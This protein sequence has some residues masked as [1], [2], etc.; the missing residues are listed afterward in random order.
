[1]ELEH[2]FLYV[3][4][5]CMPAECTGSYWV[6]EAV[7]VHALWSRCCRSPLSPKVLELPR[8]PSSDQP[9]AP[10]AVCLRAY[11]GHWS[12]NACGRVGW[13]CQRM[14]APQQQPHLLQ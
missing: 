11:S 10:A 6:T 7:E 9:Q 5:S 2:D 8:T 13:S 14:S 12:S 4:A 3:R 1:M